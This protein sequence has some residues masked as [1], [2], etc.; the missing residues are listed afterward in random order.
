MLASN[1]YE[2]EVT[3]SRAAWAADRNLEGATA[4]ISTDMVRSIQVIGSLESVAEQLGERLALG[5][6]LQMLPMPGGTP[7]EAG[8]RLEAL[9]KRL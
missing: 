9:I 7:A 3:A 6:D 8:K 2:S 5:A 1:G 4:A